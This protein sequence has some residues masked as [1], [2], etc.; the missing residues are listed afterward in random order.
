MHSTFMHTWQWQAAASIPFCMTKAYMIAA[1]HMP[2]LCG[3]GYNIHPTAAVATICT[4]V[5]IADTQGLVLLAGWEQPQVW[6]QH[7]QLQLQRLW[8]LQVQ[9]WGPAA[10]HA[11]SS[12]SNRRRTPQKMRMKRWACWRGG[13]GLVAIRFMMC[14]CTGVLEVSCCDVHA[15]AGCTSDAAG[16]EAS[17]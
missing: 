5:R 13:G 2:R 10:S 11:G 1:A 8:R 3:S 17:S 16:Q 12:S 6:R 4:C 9:L 7:Q 15:C 14:A